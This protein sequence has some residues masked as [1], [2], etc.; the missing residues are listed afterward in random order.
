MIQGGTDLGQRQTDKSVCNIS[1]HETGQRERQ[2]RLTFW[3]RRKR[4]PD[5]RKLARKSY[6]LLQEKDMMAEC[7]MRKLLVIDQQ[8]LQTLIDY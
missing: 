8:L 7:L 5:V 2:V 4:M 6:T 1:E 3:L